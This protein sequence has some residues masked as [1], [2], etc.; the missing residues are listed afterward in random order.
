MAETL[1]A[2]DLDDPDACYLMPKEAFAAEWEADRRREYFDGT[3][4]PM[5][6]A[7]PIRYLVAANLMWLLGSAFRTR[8]FAAAQSD[9]GVWVLGFNSWAYPDVVFYPL[10]GSYLDDAPRKLLNPTVLFGILSP[11][12][13]KT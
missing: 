3:V 5:L 4:I 11:S 8:P 10:L 13:G 9:C 12:I 6:G 7:S 2:I 1:T